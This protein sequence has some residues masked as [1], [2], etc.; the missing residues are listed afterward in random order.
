M[1]FGLLGEHPDGVDL[2]AALVD[3]GRHSLAAT[4]GAFP[5]AIVARLG[6]PARVSDAEEI[7]AD[8]GVEA[9]IVAGT[10]G[11]RPALLRRSLQSERHVVCVHPAD[12]KTDIAYEAA[13]L[14]QDTG[15][16][17][18]PLLPEG[19]HPGIAR[20]A[21]FLTRQDADPIGVF[22]LLTYD[23]HATGEILDSIA[24]EGVAPAFPGWDILRRL[25]GELAEVSSFADGEEPAAGLPVLLAG[26]FE[27]GG[28]FQVTLVPGQPASYWRL[29][30]I[31]T[32]GQA[33]LTWPQGWNGP[34]FLNWREGGQD[35]EEYF[36][37]YDPWP[38][39][40]EA[41]ERS[42]AK[43]PAA[44][45]WQDEVRMLELDGAAR[46]STERRRV[47]LMDYQEA[48][49]EVGFKG[50]MTLLG[51]AMLWGVI[52]IL[53]LS[54]LYAWTGWLILPL[55]LA[56]MLLQFLRYVIPAKPDEEPAGPAP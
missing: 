39:L 33:T 15:Y 37:R 10:P 44:L 41:F 25:G 17:L 27:G 2:A 24:E 18:F 56:F 45:R 22:R 5:P 52:V 46:R 28:L 30:L 34:A 3:S 32:R 40:V 14:Q 26:R 21:G 47:D 53:V 51:C 11:V 48:N 8:G 36:E 55:L 31:G 1:R 9:V 12:E 13:M 4:T 49:E 19:L 35:R 29:V 16:V 7:L 42:V 20:L 38:A 23:R 50:T 43:Q 6:N 54:R